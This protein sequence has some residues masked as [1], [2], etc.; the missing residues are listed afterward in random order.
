MQRTHE[1]RERPAGKTQVLHNAP[2]TRQNALPKPVVLK[3]AAGLNSS[4]G[5]LAAAEW[6]WL[7][8]F[9]QATG[10]SGAVC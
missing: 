1:A 6:R 10:M 2:L 7:P 9:R 4:E 8:L 5:Q 3:N